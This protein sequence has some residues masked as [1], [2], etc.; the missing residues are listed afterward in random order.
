MIQFNSLIQETPYLIFM[1]MSM[2]L[3]HGKLKKLAGVALHKFKFIWLN[4]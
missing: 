2:Q 4:Q 1:D 3:L